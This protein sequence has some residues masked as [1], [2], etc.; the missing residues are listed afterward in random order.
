MIVLVFVVDEFSGG[1]FGV[2][3]CADEFFLFVFFGTGFG[4][5]INLCIKVS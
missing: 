4:A 3:G 5:L 1:D 2:A